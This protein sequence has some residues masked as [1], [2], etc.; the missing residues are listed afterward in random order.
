[1]AGRR[2]QLQVLLEEKEQKVH[3]HASLMDF[4]H[5]NVGDARKARI[6]Y[7]SPQK[8]PWAS[9]YI[10]ILIRKTDMQTLKIPHLLCRTISSFVLIVMFGSGWSTPPP[11]RNFRL[12]LRKLAQ[13]IQVQIFFWA[14]YRLCCRNLLRYGPLPFPK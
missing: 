9:K 11:D 7:H 5:K 13:P 12:V 6:R 10:L 1:M 3:F 4:I 14:V 2:R 8:H